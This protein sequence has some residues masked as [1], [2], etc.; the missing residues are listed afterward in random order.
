M[1]KLEDV[2]GGDIGYFEGEVD[3]V[4][5]CDEVGLVL[6]VELEVFFVW[7]VGEEGE[8]GEGFWGGGGGCF[9]CVVVVGDGGDGE[10]LVW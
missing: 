9:W 4:F 7:L 5:G 1:V 3:L 6:D 10:G 2:F 8:E